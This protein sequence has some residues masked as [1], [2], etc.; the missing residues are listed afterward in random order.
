MIHHKLKEE[1]MREMIASVCN[2]VHVCVRT[3]C[4]LDQYACGICV[5]KGVGDVGRKTGV[6][7]DI[8]LSTLWK[9]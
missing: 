5:L 1:V 8:L 2:H 3:R 9:S 7:E 6:C 4:G